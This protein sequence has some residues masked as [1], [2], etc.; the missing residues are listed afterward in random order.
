MKLLRF[1]AD[2]GIATA[3]LTD[4]GVVDLGPSF[5]DFAAAVTA[6][7]RRRAAA[8]LESGAAARAVPLASV[9]LAAPIATGARII[10]IGLNYR[11]HVSEA[12]REMP[13]QPS[14]F[15]RTHQS[16]VAPGAPM[17]RPQASTHYDFEGELALVIGSPVRSIAE[18]DALGCIGGYTCFNDGSIR[19]YQ[20]HSLTVGKNFDDSGSCGPWVVTADEIPDPTRL[21]LTTRLNG[22]T[23]QH[24]TTDL[25]IYGIPFI[26]SYLSRVTQLRPGDLIATG[27]PSGVGLGRKPPLWM[28]PGDRIEVEIGGI[29]TLS[30]PIEAA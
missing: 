15:T 8:Q 30:N 14:V 28:K 25:L 29:G 7:G 24:A 5:D 20:K 19:D 9:R 18:S 12:G 26:I 1:Q 6:D 16:V 13:A 21:E 22:E 10:C 17:R 3:A 2:R 4:R 11:D 23:M 27:T